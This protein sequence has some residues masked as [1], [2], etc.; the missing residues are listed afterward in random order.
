[1][2]AKLEEKA[3]LISAEWKALDEATKKECVAPLACRTSR[4]PHRP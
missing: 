2:K 3:K 1:M 4:T